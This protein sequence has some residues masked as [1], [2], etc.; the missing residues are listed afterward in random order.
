VTS[1]HVTPANTQRPIGNL[2]GRNEKS[3]ELQK[4]VKRCIWMC[5]DH[6]LSKRL[7]A[8]SIIHPTLMILAGIL[9]STYSAPRTKTLMLTKATRL[10]SELSVELTLRG[11]AMIEEVNTSVPILT[12]TLPNREP[13][14]VLLFT[15]HPSIMECWNGLIARF[16]RR[17]G[18][19]FMP[20]NFRNFYGVKQ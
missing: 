8:G 9:I 19:C 1:G 20:V 17:C 18:Q 15:T 2:F 12:I 13:C 14:E 4:S 3:L 10:N 5:G 6:P 16:W 7:T 11:F